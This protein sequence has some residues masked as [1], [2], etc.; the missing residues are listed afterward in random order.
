[1]KFVNL[2][3]S[4]PKWLDWRKTGVTASDVSCLFGNNPYKTEWRLWAEKTGLQAEDGIEGN[5][6]VRK[7]KLFEHMLREHVVEDRDIGIFPACVEHDTIPEIKAS[8]DG[9]DR[10]GRPW[11]FKVPSPGNFELVRNERLQSEPATRY[12]LQ[13]QQQLIVTG[14]SEGYLVFGNID[15]E[16]PVPRVVEYIMLII[17][18][19]QH[20]QNQIVSRSIEFMRKVRDKIEPPKDPDRDVFAPETPETALTWKTVAGDLLPMLR[21]KAKLKQQL[22]TLEADIASKA[23]PL[24][25]VL[26]INKVGEFAGLRATR[27]DRKGNVDWQAFVK[28]KGFDPADE[29][30]VGPYRKAGS[31][32]Y[33]YAA[34]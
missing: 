12:W 13:V 20:I 34:L 33:Q 22:E 4:S 18:A 29:K 15:D 6:Y 32:N 7:G 16:G 27:V 8:L 1:M 10:G 30:T 21:A 2:A 11:E 28:D 14:A 24:L 26:G 5:P 31:T 23:E 25:Q 3:Q 17:Q 19:D 9:I